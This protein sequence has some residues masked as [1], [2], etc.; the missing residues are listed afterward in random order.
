MSTPLENKQTNDG[1]LGRL[2]PNKAGRL[3]RGSRGPG[4]RLAVEAEAGC[5]LQ[6]ALGHR[7]RRNGASSA[8]DLATDDNK[9]STT[10]TNDHNH[11]GSSLISSA[12]TGVDE[13]QPSK[14]RV[15][16]EEHQGARVG[17]L[18]RV[19]PR[20]KDFKRR[21]P[22]GKGASLGEGRGA[23]RGRTRDQVSQ[24]FFVCTCISFITIQQ[25]K[26]LAVGVM[27][28]CCRKDGKVRPSSKELLA[29]E[30]AAVDTLKKKLE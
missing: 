25:T 11:R 13:Q 19:D 17:Q 4:L 16:E 12:A 15:H 9:L 24:T 20:T 2:D 5:R 10:A 18:L 8:R 23:S 29:K 3:V 26:K 30:T 6:R 28:A 7:A 1:G 21:A 22:L 14:Q 27:C